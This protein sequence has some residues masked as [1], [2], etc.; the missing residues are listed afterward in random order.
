ML[1]QSDRLLN[2]KDIILFLQ[3]DYYSISVDPKDRE[4][5]ATTI[6]LTYI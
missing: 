6:E 5:I 4:K 1:L 2:S 3:N